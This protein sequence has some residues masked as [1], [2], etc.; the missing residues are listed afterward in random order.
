[1]SGSWVNSAATSLRLVS[2]QFSALAG[3]PSSDPIVG[4]SMQ[5]TV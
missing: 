2:N 3:A 1:M 5:N 4:G